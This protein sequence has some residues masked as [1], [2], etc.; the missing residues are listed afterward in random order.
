MRWQSHKVL[1]FSVVGFITG[2]VVTAFLS[3]LGAIIPDVVEGRGYEDGYGTERFWKWVRRHRTISHW[4]VIYATVL[5]VGF[6][7]LKYG[8]DGYRTGGYIILCLSTGG[9]CHIAQDAISGKVPLFRPFEKNFGVK[10]IR[11]G[12]VVEVIAVTLMSVVLLC[13][14]KDKLINSIASLIML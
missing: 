13:Y 11:T 4:W 9:L 7:A 10:L 2:N 12:S 1:T 8:N 14:A 5:L 6:L 3:A